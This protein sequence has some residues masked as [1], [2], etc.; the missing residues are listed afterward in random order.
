MEAIA[1]S[2]MMSSGVRIWTRART[3][4]VLPS[5]TRKVK[6]SSPLKLAPGVYSKFGAVPLRLPFVGPD[7]TLYVSESPSTCY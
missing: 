7:A 3:L 1:L 6:L 4:L 5:L 2:K